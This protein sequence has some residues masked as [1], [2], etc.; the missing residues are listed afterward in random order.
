MLATKE[1]VFK[2]LPKVTATGAFIGLAHD[3]FSA[4]GSG[5]IHLCR[6]LIYSN[7]LDS[8]S[9]YKKN[10]IMIKTT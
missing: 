6:T 9:Y 5:A 3:L 8:L 2:A 4:S 7:M 1:L 10:V